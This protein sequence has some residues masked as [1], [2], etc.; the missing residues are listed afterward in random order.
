MFALARSRQRACAPPRV[1]A[2]SR[3][4]GELGGRIRHRR[5]PCREFVETA[6]RCPLSLLPVLCAVEHG[7]DGDQI[8]GLSSL[9][10]HDVRQTRHRSFLCVRAPSCREKISDD[11]RAAAQTK[12]LPQ[13]PKTDVLW[14]DS[15]NRSRLFSVVY[16]REG[17]M[18]YVIALFLP[19]L[20][21]FTIGRPVAGII[22][23]VLQIT[24]I[25]WIP[26]TL[27]AFVAI[28]GHGA[29]K[30]TDKIV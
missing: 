29:D 15:P 8:I 28:A 26:A 25:G 5:L 21:F 19:W 7:V 11:S 13:I 30:R 9:I 14:I 17:H 3:P 12:P 22:C 16:W 18:R 23:L 27:W 4:S 10:D 1:E 20:S 2:R 24:L 6:T